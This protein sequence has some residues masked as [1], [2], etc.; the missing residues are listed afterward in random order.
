M[1]QQNYLNVRTEIMMEESVV[2]FFERQK[3]LSFTLRK[4]QSFEKIILI[5]HV[6]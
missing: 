5:N 3:N 4:G 1:H 6:N 2:F